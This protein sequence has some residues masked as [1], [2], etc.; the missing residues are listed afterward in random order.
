MIAA[1][2]S[3][4]SSQKL[5]KILEVRLCSC[6]FFVNIQYAYICLL[7][8]IHSVCILYI[9]FYMYKHIYI[10]SCSD[11]VDHLGSRELHE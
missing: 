2:V 4:K 7:L 6:L 10:M 5:K 1:S 11:V 3:I 9:I 8:I